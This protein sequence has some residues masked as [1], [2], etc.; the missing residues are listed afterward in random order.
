[1]MV[2]G[3]DPGGTTGLAVLDWDPTEHKISVAESLQLELQDTL[4]W[5]HRLP[6][7]FDIEGIGIERFVFTA[8]T[9]KLT[10]QYDALY[11]IG[12]ALSLAVNNDIPIKLQNVADAKTSFDN[13][14]LKELGILVKGP[15]AKDAA[16]HGLLYLR[17]VTRKV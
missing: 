14:N 4:R 13:E 7:S 9:T 12:A 11:V 5:L 8:R 2:L 10:A 3:I 15:H 6:A 1:M 17:S 16:R